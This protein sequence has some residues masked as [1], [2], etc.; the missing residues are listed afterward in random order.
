MVSF[1]K[2]IGF[3]VTALSLAIL[4]LLIIHYDN[5]NQLRLKALK[6]SDL[7]VAKTER[8][9]PSRGATYVYVKYTYNGQI[10]HNFFTT[11]NL[12]VLDSLKKQSKVLILVSKQH[13]SEYIGFV[14]VYNPSNDYSK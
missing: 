8:I 4:I 11:Y 1:K 2:S 6:N 7:V 3:I 9:E 12:E 5:I 10:M 13:P 14:R